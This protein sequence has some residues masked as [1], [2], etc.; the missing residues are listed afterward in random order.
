MK[1]SHKRN[2][3]PRRDLYQDVTNRIIAALENGVVPWRKPW[4]TDEQGYRHLFGLPANA[5]TGRAYSGVNVVLLW[6]E[7]MEKGYSSSKWLTFHQALQSGGNVKKGERSTLVLWYKAIEKRARDEQGQVMFD[8]EGNPV[9]EESCILKS[10]FVFNVEQCE[11]LPEEM[12]AVINDS[13]EPSTRHESFVD[14]ATYAR[15]HQMIDAI[16]VK[17]SNRGMDSAF[18]RPKTDEIF[19]PKPQC[20]FTEG[21]YWSTVLHEVVHST[22]H[23]SRMNRPG[24]TSKQISFG[25]DIYAFEELIAEIGSAFLCASLGITGELQHESYIGNWLEIM[26]GDK[27]AIVKASKFAR[28]ASQYLFSF[29]QAEESENDSEADTEEQQE[30]VMAT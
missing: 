29:E 1:R 24:I 16:G 26:K 19:L 22:G 15:I 27:K 8:E 3:Q 17:F 12:T 21:D 14:A 9:T 18:Y 7:Q 6:L 11:N 10:H 23:E 2:D 20:F 28:L 13:V 25:D 4:K 30:S 5:K